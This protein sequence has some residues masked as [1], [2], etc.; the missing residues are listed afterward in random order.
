L[1]VEK[2]VS[3]NT[4]SFFLCGKSLQVTSKWKYDTN[5]M[6]KKRMKKYYARPFANV[7]IFL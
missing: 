5:T 4:E 1:R 3:A 2:N 7:K 6:K